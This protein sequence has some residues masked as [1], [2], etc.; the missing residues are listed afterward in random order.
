MQK[1]ICVKVSNVS[2]GFAL[3]ELNDWLTKGWTVNNAY[4]SSDNS[5]LVV[6]D[7]PKAEAT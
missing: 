5:I 2:G 4:A 1:A 3:D 6:L 7:E